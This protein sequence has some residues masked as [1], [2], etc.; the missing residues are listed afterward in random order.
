MRAR[1]WHNSADQFSGL[2]AHHPRAGRGRALS[3]EEPFARAMQQGP[4][5]QSSR[6]RL[7][8]APFCHELAIEISVL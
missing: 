7:R 2:A 1:K 5:A 8:G 6:R 4:G 3:P